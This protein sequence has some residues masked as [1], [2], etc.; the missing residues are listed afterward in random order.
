MSPLFIFVLVASFL[1]ALVAGFIITTYNALQKLKVRIKAS[2]QEIGNQLK[3]QADIIP[4]ISETV[5][6]SGKHEKEIFDALARGRAGINAA[7]SAPNTENMNAATMGV[8]GILSGMRLIGESNPQLQA[9]ANFQELMKQ[10][11]TTSDKTMLS[12]RLLID[13]V[14]SYNEKINIF[15][16]NLVAS[17]FGFK[18]EEGFKVSDEVAQLDQE[19]LTTPKVDFS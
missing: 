2:L 7:I 10:L 18:E 19:A 17:A 4:N 12:R 8:G 6:G 9:N 14:A 16:A 11:E 3:R 5:K 13:L 1:I 15:P